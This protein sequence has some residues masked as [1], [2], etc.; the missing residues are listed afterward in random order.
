[1][2]RATP[3]RTS[4]TVAVILLATTVAGYAGGAVGS[5][6]ESALPVVSPEAV[7]FRPDGLDDVDRIVEAAVAERTFPGAV[8]A[9]GRRGGLVRLRAFGRQT[10][11]PE[12]AEVRTDTIYDLASLT[13]IVVTTTVAMILVD[14]GRLDLDATV[15]SIVPGFEGGAKDQVRVRQL[16]SHSGGLLWWAP[17]YKELRGKA[18]F[19]ERILE[20]DLDYPPGTKSVYSDLGLILLGEV[21]ERSAGTPIE[22]VA[23]RRLLEP[24]G[25]GDTQYLPPV[26]LRPRIAPT[27]RDP[28]RGRVLRGEVHDRNTFALGG[29][30]PHAGLFGTAGDLARFAQMLLNGGTLEGHRIVSE[31]TVT[32]FTHRVTGVPG[33]TR[34]LGWDTPT[35][36]ATPRSS[37]PGD[38]GYSSAGTLFSPRSFGHT[39]YTGTSMWIDPEREL[40][41]IL[42]SNRVHPTRENRAHLAFRPRLADAVVRALAEP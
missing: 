15:G 41:V 12:A 6:L 27:E 14:E 18:A 22:E 2:S 5:E 23:R 29:V 1:V 39:G 37:T 32:L 8:L 19:L 10:Y 3:P 42:L 36:G 7:G 21:L 28:W 33:C 4:R 30:A 11:E 34:A 13:K 26:A 16:L 40:F 24:L 35:D 38:P 25:M 31:D 20:M 9:I 17:L